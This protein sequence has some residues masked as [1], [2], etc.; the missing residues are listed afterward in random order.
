MRTQSEVR[1]SFWDNNPIFQRKPGWSQ[2][3]Y[4][5]D[6]RAA[7]VDYVDLLVRTGDITEALSQR[8]TL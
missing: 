5:A 2:N 6:I 8:V 3:D 4:H 7:F 1:S